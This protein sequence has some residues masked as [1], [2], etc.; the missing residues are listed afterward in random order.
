MIPSTPQR[1]FPFHSLSFTLL[2]IAFVRPN[3][4]KVGK[5]G[6]DLSISTPE[7]DFGADKRYFVSDQAL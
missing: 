7:A 1:C 5:F 3:R 2:K 4:D 6:Q